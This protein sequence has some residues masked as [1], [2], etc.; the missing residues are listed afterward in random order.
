MRILA[1]N[2]TY[3]PKGTTTRL[4][5]SALDGAASVGADIEMVILRDHDIQYCKNC[6]TCYKDLQSE[7]AP[8]PIEDDVS[9]ILEKIR[10]A[11]GVILASPVHNGFAT[12]LMIAFFERIAWRLCRPTGEILGLKGVPENRVPSKVRAVATIVSAGAIPTK[13]RRF[14]DDGTPWMKENGGIFFNGRSVGD[15]Y[16][17]AVL[18]KKPHGEEWYRTYLLRELSKEQLQEAFKLGVK[19]A[20]A[21]KNGKV[22]PFNVAGAI[23]PLSNIFTKVI[24]YL[25][26]PYKTT[27]GKKVR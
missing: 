6:L 10:D 3:R 27:E 13:L 24:G 2:A 18:T 23:G 12:G 9:E 7:I 25:F 19:M 11:D 21:I 22:R 5:Q 14:C 8:C 20:V 16:A 15:I 1:L 4:T 26:H 17:G